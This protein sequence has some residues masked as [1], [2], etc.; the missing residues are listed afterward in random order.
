MSQSTE[1]PVIL[2][3]QE[4]IRNKCVNTGHPDSGQEI[5]SAQTLKNFF[6][7]YGIQS[8]I[9]ETHPGRANLVARIPG[10]N[11]GS[12]SLCFMSHLD[13]VP[14]NEEQWSTDPF[15]GDL[16]G[17]FVWGRGAVDM[18]NMTAA[19]AV[20][21]AKIAEEK[22]QFPGDLVFLAVAD[23]EASGRLGARWLTENHWDKIKSD[24]MITELGGFFLA[25]KQEPNITITVGEK[26]I[27]WTRL[28][29]RGESGHGSIPFRL[30]N[31]SYIIGEALRRLQAHRPKIAFTRE[32]KDMVGN[33]SLAKSMKRSLTDRGSFAKALDRL[34]K[35]DEGTARFLHAAG[36]MTISPNVVSVG[37]KIN[38]IP[39][40]GI[41]ELDVRI[42]PGQTVETVIAEL[43]RALGPLAKSFEMEIIEYYPSNSSPAQTPLYEATQE[44]IAAVYPL[45][46]PVPFFI[47][48][49]TD[50]R[51][52]RKKGTI[53]YGFSL[54]HEELT[55]TEYARRI[56]SRDERISVESLELSYTYFYRLPKVFFDKLAIENAAD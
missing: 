54:F 18:L 2:L 19:Q 11:P 28:K 25:N 49:V 50:G 34:A 51:Y 39:D 14:A 16:R 56:H 43:N 40:Q 5:R 29:A 7:G 41:I 22:Q 3:L 31:T 47:G 24:Y 15:G 45:A 8:E 13:V 20:A 55:L 53:V 37:N 35:K 42:L 27:A 52:F 9:L 12:P 26:G 10:T 44:L 36:Q 30:T 46:K 17:G 32:Y 4:L 21:F 6:A 38:I 33:L 48:G 23:E 1:T